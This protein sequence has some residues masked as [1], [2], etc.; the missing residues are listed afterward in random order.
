LIAVAAI[1]VLKRYG[2]ASARVVSIVTAAAL[3]G[4]IGNALLVV[5]RL[6]KN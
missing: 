5:I 3:V 4:S 2:L 6:M 1:V